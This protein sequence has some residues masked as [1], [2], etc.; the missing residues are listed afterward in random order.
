M[1]LPLGFGIDALDQL[2]EQNEGD[3]P[4]TKK[5]TA[6]IMGP[7]GCGKSL[8]ALHLAAEYWRRQPHGKKPRII[9]VSTDFSYEQANQAWMKFGLI[10]PE[11]RASVLRRVTNEFLSERQL[12][13]DLKN[14]DL[15]F[16]DV[17]K[18]KKIE[19]SVKDLKAAIQG[20]ADE[21]V[22]FIDLQTQTAGDDWTFL[23]QVLGMLWSDD[24]K[25]EAN[26][27]YPLVIV[28]AVEG[29]ETFVGE[30]DAY[31]ERRTRRSRIAQTVRS[32]ARA[33]AHLV[34]VLEPVVNNRRL[35][36]QFIS[37]LVVR[38]RLQHD[39]DY[40]FRTIEIEK[41]RGG[42]H[43]RGEH[44]FTIRDGHGTS[45]GTYLDVDDP[46]MLRDAIYDVDVLHSMARSNNQDEFGEKQKAKQ[47]EARILAN[48]LLPKCLLSYIHVIP[49]LHRWN[50]VLQQEDIQVPEQEGTPL[51]IPDFGL[52]RLDD[53][54]GFKPFSKDTLI[55]H[56]SLTILLGDAGTHKSRLAR[57]FL[58][59]T[60]A[61]PAEQLRGVAVLISTGL[62]DRDKLQGRLETHLDQKLDDTRG[63]PDS[64]GM[65]DRILCRRLSV[66]HLSSAGFLE[67]VHQNI[68]AAQF[69]LKRWLSRLGVVDAENH[70]GGSAALHH[71]IDVKKWGGVNPGSD[72]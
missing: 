51:G 7:D 66:R 57:S 46:R 20:S 55:H 4:S 29:L 54:I 3:S 71:L 10:A 33:N 15:Q 39:R 35:P 63:G 68:R 11:S 22:F 1:T 2:F 45:S 18:L 42:W 13:A 25:E 65:D 56:G 17:L 9:Y 50:R 69:R 16:K 61:S 58:A 60:F 53:L 48:R 41:C 31:G 14:R 72:R 19:P 38:L 67:I 62:M 24:P 59:Q 30:R 40:A 21:Q 28:D 44:E 36:E 70:D 64:N 5:W 12:H 37:D 23:N 49:S 27:T 8:L 32:A 52:D 47:E 26:G 6:A 43:A 34:F